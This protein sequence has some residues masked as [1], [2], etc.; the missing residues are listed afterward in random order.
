MVGGPSTSDWNARWREAKNDL[1]CIRD[2]GL[3]NAPVTV[4]E[5]VGRSLASLVLDALR[6]P[7][8]GPYMRCGGVPAYADTPPQRMRNV[9]CSVHATTHENKD[10]ACHKDDYGHDRED[11][12]VAAGIRQV[13][14]L[15]LGGGHLGRLLQRLLQRLHR[16]VLRRC[17]RL[18]RRARRARSARLSRSRRLRRR[19]RRGLGLLADHDQADRRGGLMEFGSQQILI[20]IVG[21]LV[22]VQGLSRRNVRRAVNQRLNG[23]GIRMRHDRTGESV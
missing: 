21:C 10:S 9:W 14:D 6:C 22:D 18:R 5:H 13:L 7:T 19:R 12:D 4:D 17:A 20:L 15:W 23:V 1:F 16:S 2:R 8:T 11:G 3:R